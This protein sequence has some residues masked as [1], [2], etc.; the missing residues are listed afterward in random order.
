MAEQDSSPG[1]KPVGIAPGW[2]DVGTSGKGTSCQEGVDR[3]LQLHPQANSAR[4]SRCDES[5]PG[6]GAS[7]SS[8]YTTSCHV[9]SAKHFPSINQLPQVLH[10]RGLS[11]PRRPV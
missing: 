7:V 1:L 5:P 8:Y 2:V 4:G 11:Q 10:T 3:G 9:S 6:T